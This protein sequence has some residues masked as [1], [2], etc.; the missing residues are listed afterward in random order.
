MGVQLNIKD[1]RTVD[2][3]RALAE[4]LGQSVTQTIREA[5][6]EK[7][8]RGIGLHRAQSQSPDAQGFILEERN[9]EQPT[10]QHQTADEGG[11]SP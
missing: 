3:A 7:A 4:R 6:E 11:E 1:E 2:L 8:Q 5:L 9:I 10:A